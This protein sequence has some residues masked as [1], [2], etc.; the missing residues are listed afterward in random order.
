VENIIIL[1]TGGHAASLTDIVECA[2]KYKI[3]GYIDNNKN[4]VLNEKYHIIGNDK[5]LE[6]IYQSGIYNA[7]LGIGFLGKSDIREK[8]YKKLIP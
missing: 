5:D 3:A 2:G 8:L 7:A 4:E 1:G 6:D